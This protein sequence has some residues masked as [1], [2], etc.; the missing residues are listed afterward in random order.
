[1]EQTFKYPNLLLGTRLG[2]AWVFPSSGID[3][4]GGY[5]EVKGIELY[6]GGPSECS[7]YSD[8]IVMHTQTDYALSCFSAATANM[9]STDFFVLDLDPAPIGYGAAFKNPGQEGAWLDA[10]FMINSRKQQGAYYHLRFDNNGC[11]DGKRCIVWFRD[12]MFT[13]ST[14]PHAWA[15]AEG[16]VWP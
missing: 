10:T 16:E 15:P 7:V 13:E 9:S 5:N 4:G 12:I 2:K 14:E 8:K 6:N 11:T 1:M 3:V